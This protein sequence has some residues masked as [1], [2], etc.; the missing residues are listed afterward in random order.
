MRKNANSFYIL[1]VSDFHISEESQKSAEEALNAVTNKLQEMNISISYLIHT[2][3]II[4]SKDIRTK[5]EQK[6][7]IDLKDDEYDNFLDKIVSDR[8]ELAE[9]IMNKFIKQLDVLQKNIVI[10]CGNHD[11]IRYRSK[12]KNPFG[13][14]ENF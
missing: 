13:L 4:N 7:G 6:H 11:K 5:I 2:G 10:C 8:L 14:F 1:Q 9:N 12:G 3:D